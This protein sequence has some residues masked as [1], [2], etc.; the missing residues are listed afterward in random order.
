MKFEQHE[1]FSIKRGFKIINLIRLCFKLISNFKS[2][3]YIER[4][5]IY[6]KSPFDEKEYDDNLIGGKHKQKYHKFLE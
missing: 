1:K 3:L 4:I 2:N 6:A 5:L